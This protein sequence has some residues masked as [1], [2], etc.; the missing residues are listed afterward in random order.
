MELGRL[1][2]HVPFLTGRISFT[3]TQ[4]G[5]THAPSTGLLSVAT[6]G[7]DGDLSLAI[8]G[9]GSGSFATVLE[10]REWGSVVG[11]GHAPGTDARSRTR[12]ELLAIV[13][14]R[15]DTRASQVAHDNIGR[16]KGT[17]LPATLWSRPY[18]A[19]NGIGRLIW[20]Y[21][22]III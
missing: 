15:G 10:C 20:F 22:F 2:V 14:A 13:G 3:P 4:V 12:G 7:L 5:T 8:F 11:A 19:R 9:A 17:C 18:A 16:V 1:G 21:L 6:I